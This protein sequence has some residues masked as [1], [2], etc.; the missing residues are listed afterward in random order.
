MDSRN[1]ALV[2]TEW[3]RQVRSRNLGNTAPQSRSWYQ[4]P[5][6]DYAE[7]IQ[8]IFC[9]HISKLLSSPLTG[10][11]IPAFNETQKVHY[12]ALKSA[13]PVP[14]LHL[15]NQTPHSTAFFNIHF[16]SILLPMPII[17]NGLFP[18]DFSAHHLFFFLS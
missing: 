12:R 17:L 18:A 11:K 1:S 16:N 10:Q 2:S 4:C 8:N 9:A 5:L 15:I 13:P 3:N 6:T 14:V 7:R